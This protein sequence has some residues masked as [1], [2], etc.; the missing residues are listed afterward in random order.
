MSEVR[1]Q[2]IDLI[3][4]QFDGPGRSDL[5]ADAILARFEVV[6]KPVVTARSLGGLIY[7]ALERAD[8][9]PG[10]DRVIDGLNYDSV[11]VKMRDQLEA[12]GL[13]IVRIEEAGE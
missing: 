1:E 9:R 13:T 2:P 3:G 7:K 5:A 12:A 6:P 11:G 8:V 4:V 10:W